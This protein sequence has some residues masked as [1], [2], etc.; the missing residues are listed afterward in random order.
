[1]VKPV[2]KLLC[3]VFISLIFAFSALGCSCNLDDGIS[4]L[5]REYYFV[6]NSDAALLIY[7]RFD[8]DGKRDEELYSRFSGLAERIETLLSG[9]EASL[10]TDIET[11]SISRFNSAAAG[12]K[13]E[14]DFYAYTALGIAKKIYSMTG[15]AYNPAVYYSVRA[16][17]FNGASD[18]PETAEEF[19]QDEEIAQYVALSKHFGEV[20]IMQEENKYYAFKPSYTVSAGGEE[21]TLKVDLGGVGKGYAV[22]MA[23]GLIE[24]YGFQNGYFNF[25]SS[26]IA[27]KKY[28]GE[29]SDFNLQLTNPRR[30][31]ENGG[32][33]D[34]Q[35]YISTKIK[36]ECV[37]TSGDYENYFMLDANGDGV[38]ERYCHIIDPSTGKPVQTGII[39][40][41]VIGGSAAED[42]AL[43]TA[44]MAMGL[45]KAFEF[46]NSAPDGIRAVFAY[47]KDGNLRFYTNMTENLYSVTDS[48]YLPGLPSGN[49]GVYV[50]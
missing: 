1:M 12:E 41:T 49:G 8:K 48:R 50:A 29:N 28:P 20:E 36:D 3:F 24:E 37:S 21:L 35:S 18:L 22:D 46:V 19:P 40:A 39:S 4:Y 16:F 42:D 27:F 25:G 47:E 38:E 14:I 6:M 32:Y 31:A 26:S 43:T 15:G 10:S 17:G 23:D 45:E 30:R 13:V 44:I 34:S 11:S 9:L 5:K 7:D 2:K 33:I